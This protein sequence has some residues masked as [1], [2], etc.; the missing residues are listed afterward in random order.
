M[1]CL[2]LVELQ[3]ASRT[4]FLSSSLS[5]KR[6]I[7]PHQRLVVSAS[8]KKDRGFVVVFNGGRG[9]LSPD[10]FRA[11][12]PRRIAG[13]LYLFIALETITLCGALVLVYM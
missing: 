12:H 9:C 8:D 13:Y 3:S 4:D 5:L 10:V 7:V 6:P 11:L 1:P 2:P